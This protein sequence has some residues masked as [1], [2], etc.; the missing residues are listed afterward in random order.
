[1]DADAVVV[2]KLRCQDYEGLEAE[3]ENVQGAYTQVLD[4]I[5]R[6]E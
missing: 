1:M 6:I 4:V 2:E 3:L 5:M